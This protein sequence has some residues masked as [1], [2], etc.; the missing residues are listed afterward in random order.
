MSEQVPP[1]V[2][3]PDESRYHS[4]VH[5]HGYD[6]VTALPRLQ[7]LH[8]SLRWDVSKSRIVAIGV[9]RICGEP[10]RESAQECSDAD[11]RTHRICHRPYR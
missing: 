1:P 11:C 9:C 8:D 6:E 5:R 2:E 4:L 10:D 3:G 7:S